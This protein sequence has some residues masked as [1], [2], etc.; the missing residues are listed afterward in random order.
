MWCLGRFLPMIIGEW[1]PKENENWVEFLL[2]LDI[3]DILFSPEL[4]PEDI[5]K[6]ALLINDHHRDFKVLY[7]LSSFLPKMH[8][9][10]HMP[11]LIKLYV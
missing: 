5:A 6:L 1:I 10:L 3:V 7:P 11:R 2:M 8:Y 9:M 4:H